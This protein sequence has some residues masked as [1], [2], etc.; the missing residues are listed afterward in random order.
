M[1]SRSQSKRSQTKTWALVT[2]QH[3]WWCWLPLNTVVL[4]TLSNIAKHVVSNNVGQC[5]TRL[6]GPLRKTKENGTSARMHDIVFR[7]SSLIQFIN[8]CGYV[9]EIMR[10]CQSIK[11]CALS[12][13]IVGKELNK[14][15]RYKTNC[16]S[17]PSIPHYIAAL[18][19][20]IFFVLTSSL[21]DY[22]NTEYIFSQL[23][24][25]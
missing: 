1:T 24:V 10:F 14:K 15:W 4:P 20:N 21:R 17:E 2:I 8:C 9:R 11:R 5:C 13:C 3:V 22:A 7:F 25:I 18:G 6:N 16:D 12:L 23:A 19:E